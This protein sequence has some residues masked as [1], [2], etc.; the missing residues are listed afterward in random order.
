MKKLFI[1]CGAV[2]TLL[3]FT[4]FVQADLVGETVLVERHFPFL[5]TVLGTH[6]HS[7]EVTNDDSDLVT[8]GSVFTVDVNATNMV[9]DF[10][11]TET[12]GIADFNG[13]VISD[14][15]SD[16]ILLN[17]TVETDPGLENW[18]PLSDITFGDDFAAFN[19]SGIQFQSTTPFEAMFEFGPNP[20]PIPATMVLFVTG[21]FG[22]AAVR[23][24]IRKH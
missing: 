15:S 14:W 5:N 22:F 9:V 8:F 20:I 1:V 2:V 7:V 21:L 23:R 12:F 3:L 13:L 18:D 11:K 16:L 17:V 6:S 24:L 10:L 19:W 4:G